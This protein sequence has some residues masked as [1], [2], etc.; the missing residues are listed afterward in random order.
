MRI[1]LALTIL[2]W[3]LWVLPSVA[4]QTE[5]PEVRGVKL[6]EPQVERWRI[7]M[8]VSASGGPCARMVG[9]TS[10]PMDWPEQR[11]TIVD[12]DLTPGVSVS[13]KTYGSAVKQMIVKIP[14]LADG[15]EARA[16]ITF[17]IE[18]NTLLPPDNTDVYVAPDPKTLKGALKDY[19]GPSPTIESGHPRIKA[20]AREVGAG[21]A[22]AWDRVSA[23]YD[24]VRKKIQYEKDSPLTG[25]VEAIDKGSGDC[26]ELTSTFIALC[27]ASGIPA[28]T[29]RLPTHCYPEFY[30]LDDQGAGHWFPCEAS[31]SEAFGGIL[32]RSPILQK[33]DNFRLSVPDPGTKRTKVEAYRFLPEN[34]TGIPRPNGG[35]PQMKRVCQPIRE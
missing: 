3:P 19:L 12:Q 31:G 2:T 32:T 23:F 10:V 4:V 26:N 13:Y 30:L 9:T 35:Q 20:L 33:G 16:I 5:T 29:V 34:L 28:R 24:W 27:R 6:G 7:G 17:E 11:A 15:A 21:Q 18:R 14:A 22:K 1:P 25:V 8:V